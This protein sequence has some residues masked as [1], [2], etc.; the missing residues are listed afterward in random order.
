MSKTTGF[1]RRLG[2][3]FSRNRFRSELD[4][5]MAF[6]RDQAQKRFEAEGMSTSDARF[7]AKRQFG[8]A[9][10]LKEQSH[11]EVG[12][13]LETVGQDLRYALRQLRL[14]PGFTAVI[15]LTLALSIGANSAIF[16]VIDG[17]LL[18]SL[19]YPEPDRLTRL[20]LTS[21]AFPQFPMNPWDFHDLRDQ[22][23]SFDGFAAYARSDKQLS[24]SGQPVR[25]YAFAVTAGFFHTLGLHPQIG[26]E[27]DH[28]TEIPGNDKVV[29]LSDRLWR[30]RFSA[31]PSVLGRKITLNMQPYTI[32]AVMPAGTAH[33]GNS[34]RSVA[35]GSSV[36]LWVPFAFE[37]KPTDRGSHFMDVIGR[38][39]PG[40]TEQQAQDELN[41]LLN[42][43]WIQLSPDHKNSST[44]RLMLVPLFQEIVGSNRNLLL[45]L[46]GAVAIVLLIACVNAANLLLARAAVR[47]KE[48]AVRLALGAA[49]GRILRQL[50]T[51]SLIVS[52]GAGALGAM[53]AIFGTRL[54]VAMLPAGFPRA[55]EIHVNAAVFAFTLGISALTGILFGLV[56]AF[57]ASRHSPNQGLHEG[58][59]GMTG[60]RK[61]NRLRAALVISEISLACVLLAGSGLLL[62][63]FL[64]QLNQ[65]FGFARDHV[66]TGV[67]ALPRNT[68]QYKKDE[69]VI[70][71]FDRLQVSLAMLPGVQSAG[72]GSDLPWTGSNDNAGFAIEGKQ[73][74]PDDGF[75]GR[76]HFATPDYFRALGV[77]L[78][79]G[80]FFTLSDIRDNPKVILINQAMASSYWPGEDAV[81]KR[82][83]FE[84]NPKE[85]DWMTIVGVVGDVKDTPSSAKAPNGFWWPLEQSPNGVPEMSL[86]LRTTGDSAAL[87]AEVREQ[88]RR[89]DPDLAV[90]DLRLMDDI[91]DR[92]ISE[93]RFLFFLVSLF[94]GL[95]VLLAA[96]GIYGVIAYS[97]SQRMPEFGLRLALGASPR[98]LMRS[99]LAKA[100]QLAIAGTAAGILAAFLLGRLI[101]SL[102]YN[103]SPADPLTLIS[104]SVAVLTIALLAC[105]VPARRATRADPMTALRAE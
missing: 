102:V 64:N 60:S 20:Y 101:R 74:P 18:R 27:F 54:L 41:A 37:G 92:S 44:W 26:S 79:R 43:I 58:S 103:V 29:I 87:A 69:N 98:N 12:F 24:G 30:S 73:A 56:P 22:T 72:I 81:G 77:P 28:K 36:D 16:S 61:Q 76:Y 75:H 90:A 99:V 35:Y 97:V 40:V 51:E 5:E 1:F 49:R 94:A 95:A 14:N 93:P 33:P 71:F 59:R 32:V 39:K 42:N 85:K 47:Q 25:L 66:L 86:V 53:L 31:D 19:P 2:L 89:L 21:Q 100:A 84:D 55:E 38:L 63:S 15:M 34:Y 48:F 88:V 104:V 68:D 9:T 3:L 80:R 4:E 78:I 70:Q 91:V 13:R 10:R 57:Q 45:V 67:I 7:A 83:T 50:L 6:H 82:I 46:L 96:I 52:L 8:N 105:Y 62:R 65:S 17:V 23:H 11:E